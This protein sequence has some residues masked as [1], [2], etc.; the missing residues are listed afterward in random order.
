M[1]RIGVTKMHFNLKWVCF[2]RTWVES[3]ATI[4]VISDTSQLSVRKSNSLKKRELRS[5]LKTLVTIPRTWL[6]Y[7]SNASTT[8]TM[9]MF[10]LWEARSR[11]VRQ[12]QLWEV[13]WPHWWCPHLWLGKCHNNNLSIVRSKIRNT[14]HKWQMIRQLLLIW[15]QAWGIYRTWFKW[16]Q[17]CL[18]KYRQW[19]V[20]KLEKFPWR[21]SR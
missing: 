13:Q 7:V 21:K 2:Q 5:S 9:Q 17:M 20:Y 3:D 4:A 15:L 8:V 18:L 6:Y 14:A 16:L 10:V 19:Q 1:I 12:M 11:L